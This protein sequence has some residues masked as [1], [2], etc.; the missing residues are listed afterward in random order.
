MIEKI[1]TKI[2]KAIRLYQRRG[3]RGIMERFRLV[4]PKNDFLVNMSYIMNREPIPFQKEEW[5]RHK[6]DEVKIINWIIPEMGKGSGG[7]TTIF[8]MMSH[9]ENMGF[10]SRVYLFLSPN[11]RDNKSVKEF[12]WK[13]FPLVDKRIEFFWDV[14]QAKFAHVTFAT[15]WETAYFVRNFENTISK[16]YFVQDFEPFF[17]ANGALYHLAENTYR[18]GLR[19]I[20]A[21]DWLRDKL[22]AEYG[23]KTSSFHFSYDKDVYKPRKKNGLS[24]KVFFYARPY[25]P[26]RDFEIGMLALEELCKRM[27]KLEVIFAGEDLRDYVIPFKHQNNGIV[28]VEKL[29][30]FYSQC[31]MCLVLSGTNL[32]LLPLEIMASNSV[33][34][35]S[36]G[37]NSSWMINEENAILVDYDPVQIADTMED[38]YKH[39]EK[40]AEMRKKGISFARQTSWEKEAEKI[41]D[42][43]HNAIEEDKEKL[44]I[45]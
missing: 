10:H 2:K 6:N 8:R 24:Y 33:A 19:G 29:A 11:Y 35:C 43:L 22:S 14:S 36:K 3:I 9:L 39:P 13:Y 30:K 15:S 1:I 17:F 7:H 38:Y 31:D 25:T 18:F 42:A 34:V 44:N 28:T 45:E 40:L 21:G 27:P 32:S 4:K 20:T 26:R 5:N 23:M 41:K 12:T 37:D 16:C